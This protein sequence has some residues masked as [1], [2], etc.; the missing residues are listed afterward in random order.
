LRKIEEDKNKVKFSTTI[1]KVRF[2][3]RI[4]LQATFY[5]SNKT[6]DIENFVKKML[7]EPDEEFYLYTIPP[8]NF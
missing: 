1:I 4:D 2:P 5:P 7:L 8:K 6:E 3:N